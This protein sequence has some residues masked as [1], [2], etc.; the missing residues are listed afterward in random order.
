MTKGRRA[1]ISEEMINT[2]VKFLEEGN[3]DTV[4]AQAAGISRPTFYRY[5]RRGK[6]EK[7]GIYYDFYEAVESAKARGEVNLLKTIKTASQRTWQAAAWM[8]ERSRPQRWALHKAK[9]SA[10]QY[11]KK[12]IL[13]LLKDKSITPDEVVN[14]LGEDLAYE[15][16]DEAGISV[17]RGGETAEESSREREREPATLPE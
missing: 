6:A 17:D 11:W 12:E 2:V 14:E 8:L 1:K 10:V 3:Y 7:S 15:L 16:F 13:Q 5:I 4:A 9:D